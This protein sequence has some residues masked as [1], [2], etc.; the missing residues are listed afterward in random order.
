MPTITEDRQQSSSPT[1]AI[2][3]FG[4]IA[5]G[6][7]LGSLL[8][9]Y[10]QAS[11]LAVLGSFGVYAT[12]TVPHVQAVLMCGFASLAIV[13]LAID[14]KHHGNNRPVIFAAAGVAVMVGTL[15]GYYD[16]RILTFA[17]ILLICAVFFNQTIALKQLYAKVQLQAQQL[18]EW[19]QELAQ[20]VDEQ[21][22]RNRR[23][24]RL[25]R[26]LSP[27][28]AQIVTESA[29]DSLLESHR[30]LITALFCDL[31]GFTAL[32]EQIEPEEAMDLLK[33][34]HEEMGQ[35][36]FAYGGT[37][38]HRAGDGI[39]VIFNDPIPCDEP[40]LQAVKLAAV[41]RERVRALSDYWKKRGYE[42]GFGVGIA[43]GYATLGIV[44]HEGRFDYT[45]NGN[46]VN[47]AARLSDE[48]KN[49][50]ILISRIVFAQIGNRVEVRPLPALAL[51]GISRPVDAFDVVRIQE[52]ADEGQSA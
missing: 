46:V 4:W 35:L 52:S 16:W 6:C 38:D 20:R 5:N 33:R 44:G 32:T 7:T 23:L 26:F 45:A 50:Q 48:A 40:E 51:K 39:M 2:G 3:R 21:V 11:L 10:G 42:L 12:E 27:Q 47:L 34:Y 18:A 14:R 22:E 8:M 41:M 1:A 15:Y 25:R 49:E 37:I 29:D 28:V 24:D 36:I 31:R 30:R 9:C 13:G 43:S 19:N 17:Y